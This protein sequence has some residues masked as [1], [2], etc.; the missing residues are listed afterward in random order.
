MLLIVLM[1]RR[2]R[3]ITAPETKVSVSLEWFGDK[4]VKNCEPTAMFDQFT[5]F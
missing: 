3:F 4:S 5:P 1:D 2:T